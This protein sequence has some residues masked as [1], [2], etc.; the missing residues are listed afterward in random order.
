MFYDKT[1]RNLQ[2]IVKNE[3]KWPATLVAGEILRCFLLILVKIRGFSR[4]I[5][6]TF[7]V[8]RG[9][10]ASKF[11]RF[12]EVF[13][14][15]FCI[16]EVFRGRLKRSRFFEVADTLLFVCLFSNRNP[17]FFVFRENVANSTLQSAANF[18]LPSFF[19]TA[20]I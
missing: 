9:F 3:S 14:G 8:F 19:L 5:S 16:F 15:R 10:L 1:V 20:V 4:L 17:F 13:R 18:F 12:F 11:S 6:V 7:E 2:K